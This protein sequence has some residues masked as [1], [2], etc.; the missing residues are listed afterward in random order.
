MAA[1]HPF[2]RLTTAKLTSH[3]PLFVSPSRSRSGRSIAVTVPTNT[4][5]ALAKAASGAGAAHEQANA[6]CAR[7]AA[8]SSTAPSRLGRRNP[9]P[10]LRASKVPLLRPLLLRRI[11]QRLRQAGQHLLRHDLP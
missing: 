6:V 3:S 11:R 4:A 9:R 2:H 10:P 1:D 8:A 5:D 7:P